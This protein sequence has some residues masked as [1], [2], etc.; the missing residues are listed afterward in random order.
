MGKGNEVDAGWAGTALVAENDEN[1]GDRGCDD[2]DF[3][4]GDDPKPSRWGPEDRLDLE[5]GESEES[6][7]E[8]DALRCRPSRP[9]VAGDKSGGDSSGGGEY[10]RY[11][12]GIDGGGVELKYDGGDED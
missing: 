12:C 5:S 11:D 7:D 1:V 4:D 3:A 8:V 10:G 6:E 9:F 2:I